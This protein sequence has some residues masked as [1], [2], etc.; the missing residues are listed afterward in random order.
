MLNANEVPW[1]WRCRTASR[2]G[3]DMAKGMLRARSKA[4]SQAFYSQIARRKVQRRVGVNEGNFALQKCRT[5]CFV[6]WLFRG[7]RIEMLANVLRAF[8]RT[9]GRRFGTLGP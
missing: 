8:V 4:I 1:N 7:K 9:P 2:H 3:K 5:E 6:D